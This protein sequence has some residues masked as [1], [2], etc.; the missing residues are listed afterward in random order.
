M[1]EGQYREF[2]KINKI[3]K[4]SNPSSRSAQKVI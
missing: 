2:Q 4:Q 3:L 1:T